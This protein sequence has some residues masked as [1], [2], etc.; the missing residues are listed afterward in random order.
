MNWATKRN[1]PFDKFVG[2][3]NYNR[4]H[5]AIDT[6]QNYEQNNLSLKW[7]LPRAFA[8]HYYQVKKEKMCAKHCNWCLPISKCLQDY[9]VSQ[10][11]DDFL[12]LNQHVC[13]RQRISKNVSYV[14][15]KWSRCLNTKGENGGF[16]ILQLRRFLAISSIA[17]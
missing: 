5:F 4:D 6:E 16:W 1:I 8:R 2:N 7:H 3:W 11:I 10:F 15:G 14:E 17:I 12:H 13:Q 9:I